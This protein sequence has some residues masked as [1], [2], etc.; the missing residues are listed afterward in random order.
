MRRLLLTLLLLLAALPPARAAGA[1]DLLEPD[2]A[3]RFS[4]RALDARTVE[5]RYG[6]AD[7]YYLYRER[8]RFAAEPATV[9]LGQPQ[10]PKGEIHEDRFFG[11]Q[12][13]YRKEVRIRLPVES[14]GADRVKLLVTSQGCADVGVCYVPQVQSAELRLASAERTRSSIFG[15]DEPLVSSPGRAADSVASAETRFAGVP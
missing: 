6:I 3:F 8:F 11:K 12:E 14:S 2:K 13:T 15:K 1:D 7:G 10:F 4:A 5:V 9:T